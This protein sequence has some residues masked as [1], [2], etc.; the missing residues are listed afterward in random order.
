MPNPEADRSSPLA[1]AAFALCSLI[2]G[3][4]FLAIRLGTEVVPPLWGAALRLGLATV[5]LF[6][7]MR[8]RGEALP[9]G[10]AVRAA[11][12]FGLLNFGASFCLLYWG[13][14]Y[15][16]S[17]LT[18]VL[19][20]TIP[21]STAIFARL[22]GL[23][24]LRARTVLGAVIALAGVTV[25]FAGRLGG[26]VPAL[27]LLALLTAATCAS[28]SGIALKLGPR[29]GPLGANVVAAAVGTVVC[30]TASLV[31]GESRA[32]PASWAAWGPILYLTLA[33]SVVAFVTYAWLVNRWPVTRISFI[34]VIVPLVALLLGAIVRHERL[35]A[36]GAAGSAL[37]LAGVVMSLVAG[38]PART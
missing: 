11:A 32:W 7:L 10:A 12:M 8:A 31:A 27:P 24:P 14:Q 16:A 20:A 4:T 33:G 3:S 23:E 37:V 29:Q 30:A 17:G 6:A 36:A 28:A 2:W 35:S 19:Y 34:A 13:E 38:R 15:V 21:L 25:I 26:T 22:V 18:A 9:R 1:P 5:L